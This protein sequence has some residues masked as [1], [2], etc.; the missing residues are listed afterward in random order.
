MQKFDTVII[1]GGASGLMAAV[2]ASSLGQKVL[3]LE[4]NSGLGEK[5]LLA[6]TL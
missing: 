3:I 2:R 6:G 4:K 5:I 1:G